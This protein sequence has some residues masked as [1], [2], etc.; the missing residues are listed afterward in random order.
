MTPCS[1]SSP[2]AG[3]DSAIEVQ[4]IWDTGATRSVVTQRV[5]DSCGLV[6]TGWTQVRHIGNADPE[7]VPTYE[8]D[9][10]LPNKVRC[11][12]VAVIQ[13]FISETIGALIGMDIIT[14]GDFAVTYPEGKTKFSFR[15]PPQADIDFVSEDRPGNINQSMRNVLNAKK[16]SAPSPAAREENRRRRKKR[17]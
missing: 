2:D 1:V 5:I 12:A 17:K 11:P 3:G 8:A 14:R 9:I 15:V 7:W 4:A 13:G 10:Y 6:Q 16:V